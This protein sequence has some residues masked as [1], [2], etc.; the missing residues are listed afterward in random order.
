MATIDE[1][2]KTRIQKL[3]SL[4][5]SGFLAYPAETKRTHKIVEVIDGFSK[6]SK[7]KKDLV[8]VG[9]I[10]ALRGHGGATFLD[11]QDG[12]GKIQGLI[13]E[14]KVGEKGYKFFV[15]HF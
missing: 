3:K 7:S 13:K 2:R 12:T 15:D 14:D 9:R 5:N 10:M 11:I 1:L 8:L 4:E 6:L